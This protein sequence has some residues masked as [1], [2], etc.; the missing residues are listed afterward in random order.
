MEY[1]HFSPHK[2][3]G[4]QLTEETLEFKGKKILYML[5]ELN[6]EFILG[7]DQSV[8]TPSQTRTAIVK[9]YINKW[10][11]KDSEDGRRIS[12]LEPVNEDVKKE[13]IELIRARHSISNIH[14]G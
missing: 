11:Y 6:E 12:E 14:F 7:C 9:G 1:K 5:S 3:P 13:V 8:V 4:Y 2:D 10:Q